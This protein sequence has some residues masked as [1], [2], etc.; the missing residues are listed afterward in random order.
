ML[1]RYFSDV[2]KEKWI[3]NLIPE[4]GDGQEQQIHMFLGA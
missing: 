4:P 2:L 3:T 1:L